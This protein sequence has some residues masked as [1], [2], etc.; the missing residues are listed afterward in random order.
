MDVREKNLLHEIG[1]Q[2]S[3][4]SQG[5]GPAFLAVL[6]RESEKIRD[7]DLPNIAEQLKSS[8][9]WT[10]F[11]SSV[12]NSKSNEAELV[13]ALSALARI[14]ENHA[15]PSKH[16]FIRRGDNPIS[17]AEPGSHLR[18]LKPD[19]VM[20]RNTDLTTIKNQDVLAIVESKNYSITTKIDFRRLY[21]NA[22]L[23]ATHVLNDGIERKYTFAIF[24]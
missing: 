2:F 21:A 13:G 17:D 23:K 7:V 22:I 24:V 18:S 12:G 14:L 16:T 19:I 3:N 6:V 4:T 10:T 5:N 15:G 11:T 20:M 8:Q 1:E 9:E